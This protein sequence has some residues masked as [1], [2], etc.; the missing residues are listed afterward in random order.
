MRFS[1][2]Y[3]MWFSYLTR[4]CFLTEQGF[5]F[6]IILGQNV[7]ICSLSLFILSHI[8]FRF[9]FDLRTYAIFTYCIF[10]NN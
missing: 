1:Q 6:L 9:L 4:Y 7:G 5:Q 8:L 10:Y 3:N 2:F